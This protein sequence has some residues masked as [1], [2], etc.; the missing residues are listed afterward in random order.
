MVLMYPEVVFFSLDI[1]TVWKGYPYTPLTLLLT[2][3]DVLVILT[4]CPYYFP[5]DQLQNLHQ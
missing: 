3:P 5:V 4:G 1:S 2:S